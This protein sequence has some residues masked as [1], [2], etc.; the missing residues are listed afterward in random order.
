[1]VVGD[2]LVANDHVMREHAAH[3]FVEAAAD[4][5]VGHIEGREG[6]RAAGMNFLHGLLDAV[7]PHCRGISLE[8]GAGAVA[9]NGIAPFGNLP[10]KFDFRL[11]RGLGQADFHAVAGGF[12]I[13]DVHQVSQARSSTAARWGRRRCR[14]PGD[15]PVRSSYQRGDMTQV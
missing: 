4:G 11:E 14:A 15:R 2:L 5:L 13:A 12:D 1:M 10:L 8:I 6:L 3:G 7:E 9:F